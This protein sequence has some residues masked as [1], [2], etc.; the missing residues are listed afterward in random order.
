MA[1]LITFS[2][3]RFDT[4]AERPN[5]INP[6]AGEALLHWL[7]DGLA[8]SGYTVTA[9]EPEDWGW[10]LEAQGPGGAYLVGASGEPAAP[11]VEVEWV[12]QIHK[13]RRLSE[14]LFGKNRLLPDDALTALAHRLAVRQPDFMRV[15][16]SE[17]A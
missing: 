4:A 1:H 5:P 14:K 12:L 15:E 17:E 13:H 10:Y 3:S 6:I 2:T 7:R 16:L 9:P 11:G 8:A